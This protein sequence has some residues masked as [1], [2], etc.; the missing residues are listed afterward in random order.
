MNN[1][2]KTFLRI[3]S[4]SLSLSA[5]RA[6]AAK[7]AFELAACFIASI[8]VCP[9]LSENAS[10]TESCN[11]RRRTEF[12]RC[13]SSKIQSLEL[14]SKMVAK[15]GHRTG[16]PAPSHWN[17]QTNSGMIPMVHAIQPVGASSASKLLLVTSSSCACLEK[18]P[19]PHA[20]L[21]RPAR[22]R[23]G[24]GA[25]GTAKRSPTLAADLPGTIE[26]RCLQ[27][28][29]YGVR[30]GLGCSQR[31]A[32]WHGANGNIAESVLRDH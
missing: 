8:H 18:K 7:T 9:S 31:D 6:R 25:S 17:T 14:T 13:F 15:R 11:L 10:P 20:S 24:A 28:G 22:D 1:R 23:G 16:L 27:P 5:A 21:L 30:R 26:R 2:P 12:P 4:L 32:P 29:W 3:L 19:S